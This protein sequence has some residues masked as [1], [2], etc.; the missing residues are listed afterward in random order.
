MEAQLN[1]A[2]DFN[3]KN[4]APPGTKALIFES[5]VDRHT[6]APHGVDS[7]YLGPAPEQYRCYRLYVPKTRA[8]R[9][10]KT[11]QFFPHQCPVPKKSSVDAETLT[12]RALTEAL[13]NPAPA[14]PFYHF[15]DAH[16]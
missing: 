9:T 14:A 8:K 1:G 12:E 11:V 6:W 10:S 5:S 7:W 3:K 4:L 2:F 16:Q 15:G 13:T